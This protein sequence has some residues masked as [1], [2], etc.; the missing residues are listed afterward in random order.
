MK[1][2]KN[3]SSVRN[4]FVGVLLA[5]FTLLLSSLPATAALLVYEPFDYGSSGSNLS[6]LTPDSAGTGLAGS[7]SKGQWNNDT[8]REV[9]PLTFSTL[10]VNGGRVSQGSNYS[11]AGNAISLGATAQ[12]A[13]GTIYLSYLFRIDGSTSSIS[14]SFSAR[15]QVAGGTGLQAYAVTN[16]AGSTSTSL[17]YAGVSSVSEQSL[18]GWTTYMVIAEFTNVGAT[19]TADNPGVATLWVINEAQY[20]YFLNNGGLST[21]AL[22]SASIAH[23]GNNTVTSRTSVTA[24]SGQVS[25]GNGSLALYNDPRANTGTIY[26]RIDEIRLATTLQDALTGTVVASAIPESGAFGM[27]AGAASLFAVFAFARRWSSRR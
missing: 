7:W 4:A 8:Y 17:S 10:P 2:M 27:L 1:P 5:G 3:T 22:N 16:T 24:T 25:L 18:E 12:A 15:V 19:L 13:T 23:S 6:G 21:T 11:N 14:T 9:N 20:S 26:S